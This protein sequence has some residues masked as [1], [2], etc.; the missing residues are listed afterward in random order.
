MSNPPAGGLTFTPQYDSMRVHPCY[1]GESL[2][3]KD[4]SVIARKKALEFCG[5]Q[6]FKYE[7]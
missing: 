6:P 7:K 1:I 4:F 2:L 5:A 3:N